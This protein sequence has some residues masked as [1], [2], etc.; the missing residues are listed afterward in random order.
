MKTAAKGR[1]ANWSAADLDRMTTIR[2][3]DVDRA[4][5]A[6]RRDAPGPFKT[7]LRAVPEIRVKG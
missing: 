5:A 3:A 1:P 7:L 2:S 6:W 4:E